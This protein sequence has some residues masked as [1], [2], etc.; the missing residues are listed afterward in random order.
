M[1]VL[2][3]LYVRSYPEGLYGFKPRSAYILGGVQEDSAG[4][5][6]ESR[7]INCTL[8]VVDLKRPASISLCCTPYRDVQLPPE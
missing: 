8:Y 7:R 3:M 2:S 5:N 6:L 4:Y 1:Y